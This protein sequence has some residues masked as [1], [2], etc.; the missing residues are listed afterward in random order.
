MTPALKDLSLQNVGLHEND[1][2]R[3]L[4]YLSPMWKKLDRLSLSPPPRYFGSV[5]P[6]LSALRSLELNGEC[7]EPIL[8]Y[9]RR[10]A[11]EDIPIATLNQLEHFRFVGGFVGGFYIPRIPIEISS[12]ILH[13]LKPKVPD[14]K[15][16]TLR[17]LDI[18]FVPDLGY[19]TYIDKKTIESL[20]CNDIKNPSIHP[21]GSPGNADVFLE[22]LDGFPNLTTLGIFPEMAEHAWM[23]V[24]KAIRRLDEKSRVER[25]YTNVLKGV[26]RDEIIELAGK[27]GIQIIHADRV[28]PPE[29]SPLPH[30]EVAS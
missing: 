1:S 27:K 23:I 18:D 30:E 22:W 15:A 21:G 4:H 6:E 12:L 26:Y 29:L 11:A 25:I 20:S 2:E 17:S 16:R 3:T 5:F 10:L 24:A 8:V 28:P 9:E 13:M 7:R 19:D 14:A